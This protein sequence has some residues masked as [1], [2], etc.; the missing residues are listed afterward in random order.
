MRKTFLGLIGLMLTM[1]VVSCQKADDE[2]VSSAPSVE[3]VGRVCCRSNSP[4][5]IVNH[6]F[7]FSKDGSVGTIK[8]NHWGA[9]RVYFKEKGKDARVRI[10]EEVI[11][12]TPIFAQGGNIVVE[13]LSE[14][15]EV[16]DTHKI[17]FDVIDTKENILAW[18]GKRK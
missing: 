18:G 5:K 7:L 12:K 11:M 16:I 15:N 2:M 6:S 8:T 17:W 3:N 13:L 9:I 10:E 1:S 4:V 14:N